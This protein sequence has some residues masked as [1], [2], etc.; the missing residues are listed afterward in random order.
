MANSEAV[1]VFQSV[2]DLSEETEGKVFFEKLALNQEIE[3][4]AFGGVL[5]DD[6]QMAGT[7]KN[8]ANLEQMRVIDKTHERD[9]T[10]DLEL[11]VWALFEG[12][13]EYDL[14]GDLLLRFLIDGKLDFPSRAHTQRLDDQVWTDH[15][16]SLCGHR[17]KWWLVF[18]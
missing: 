5:E 18:F 4:L 12:F 2:D 10:L 13:F 1:E 3:E 15:D 9:L 16:L 11:Q 6:V 8:F 17:S 7:F 14:D